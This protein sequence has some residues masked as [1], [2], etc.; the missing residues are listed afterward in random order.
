MRKLLSEIYENTI[1]NEKDTIEMEK[2]I[3]EQV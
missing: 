2:R 1:K 3:T